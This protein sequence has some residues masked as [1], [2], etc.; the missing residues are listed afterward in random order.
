MA[1]NGYRSFIVYASGAFGPAITSMLYLIVPLRAAEMGA[2]VPQIGLVVSCAAVVPAVF[3]VTLGNLVDLIGVKVTFVAGSFAVAAFSLC[4]TF[5]NSVLWLMPLQAVVGAARS[6]S[7]VAIQSYISAYG[8]PNER[9]KHTGRFTFATSLGDMAG[10]LVIGLVSAMVGYRA[11]FLVVTAYAGLFGVLG[12]MLSRTAEAP[13]RSRGSRT[14][15]RAAFSLFRQ[16]TMKAVLL[17]TVCRIWLS[18]SWQ[19]FFPLLLVGA[20]HSSAIGGMMVSTAGVAATLTTL[21]VDGLV[22]RWSAEFLGQVALLVGA[23]GLT[24]SPWCVAT[25]PL[26]YFPALLLGI[27]AG[28]SLPLLIVLIS[29]EV[30]VGQRGVALG[31]RMSANS[32][33]ATGAPSVVGPM[34]GAVGQ[35]ITFPACGLAA[36]GLIVAARHHSRK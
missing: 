3:A 6:L 15:F 17:L 25:M 21:T 14:G 12:I 22:K 34:I 32:A 13:S 36:V 8:P 31:M 4:F 35:M 5:V 28:V 29:D 18:S 16:S 24:V 33:A 19:S 10:P 27:S 2:T 23:I 20:G 11:S 1:T 7:W 30:P 9:G 26:P